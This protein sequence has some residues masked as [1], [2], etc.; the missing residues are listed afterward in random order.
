[1]VEFSCSS[2]QDLMRSANT[3]EDDRGAKSSPRP[4]QSRARPIRARCRARPCQPASSLADRRRCGAVGCD[5]GARLGGRAGT[6]VRARETFVERRQLRRRRLQGDRRGRR[7]LAGD[8]FGRRI[9]SGPD[10]AARQPQRARVAG[11]GAGARVGSVPVAVSPGT[12]GLNRGTG[13]LAIRALARALAI[14]TC[15]RALAIRTRARAFAIRAGVRRV[16][17]EAVG[18]GGI[19][20][21]RQLRGARQYRARCGR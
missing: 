20:F 11:A 18:D 10:A 15:A 1:M 12:V 13:A 3:L 8:R 14:R 9:Q 21:N 2:Y 17:K 7:R 19:S 5:C 16:L 6:V 4:A